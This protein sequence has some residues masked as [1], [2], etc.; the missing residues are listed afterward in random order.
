VSAHR[1]SWELVNG[2]IADGMFVCHHCDTPLCVNPR[3]L[4]LGT[5]ADNN[6]DMRA[7]GRA[8][9]GTRQP[10]AKLTEQ[11]VASIRQRCEAGESR[12]SLSREYGVTKAI[13]DRVVNRKIWKHV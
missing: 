11:A 13:I 12:A 10:N 8:A 1:F 9:I 6:T 7:K 5:S 3:H 2:P 4:F